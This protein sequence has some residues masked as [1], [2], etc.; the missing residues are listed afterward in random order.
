MKIDFNCPH[1]KKKY[2]DEDDKY[3]DRCNRN[4]SFI[5]KIKCDCGNKFGMCYDITGQARGFD[6]TNK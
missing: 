2:N 5:T 3:L 4:K 1:C 6:L